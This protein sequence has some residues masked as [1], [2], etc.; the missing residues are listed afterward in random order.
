[1]QYI[2]F[3][4]YAVFVLLIC[5]CVR[6]VDFQKT[7]EAEV[8]VVIEG[9]FT[10]QPGRQLVFISRP[11]NYNRQV[12]ES[13]FGADLQLSD[14]QGNVWD[15]VPSYDPDSRRNCYEIADLQGQVGRSYAL[16]VTLSDG[17]IFR[18]AP[19]MLKAAI[20]IDSVSTRIAWRED[21]TAL[22]DVIREPYV[23]ADAHY[24]APV[25]T[26]ARCVRWDGNIVYFFNEYTNPPPPRGPKSCYITNGLNGRTFP[27]SNPG[28]FASAVAVTEEVGLRRYDFA[29]EVKLCFT[30][31][32]RTISKAAYD[33]W[34]QV[35]AITNPTGTLF[36]KPPAPVY[37]NMQSDNGDR[38]FGFFEVA[39][40][41]TKRIY[42][43]DRMYPEEFRAGRPTPYC[44]QGSIFNTQR[45][46]FC[47]DCLELGRSTVQMP[48]WWE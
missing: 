25:L 28:R 27:I 22:G 11:G 5:N 47:Y 9:Y 30:V 15:Y 31:N 12:F 34:Q 2:T 32:Q 26:D 29:F 23:Y 42:V 48:P 14:D 18:S 20:P 33:Y 8:P 35:N 4:K 39:S 16:T 6:E 7:L 36:D 10:D 21:N 40:V 43:A 24:T 38:T 44:S 17:R 3:L 41:V 45:P 1:M 46:N 19:Q 37:G 13:V